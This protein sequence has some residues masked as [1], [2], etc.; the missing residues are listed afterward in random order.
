[1]SL[2]IQAVNIADKQYPLLLREPKWDFFSR[3]QVSRHLCPLVLA[4]SS[5]MLL[6]RVN[7]SYWPLRCRIQGAVRWSLFLKSLLYPT[8]MYS[9]ITFNRSFGLGYPAA[10][11]E[12]DAVSVQG[13]S[14]HLHV[15]KK[16]RT[17]YRSQWIEQ[18]KSTS[19]ANTTRSCFG[20]WQYALCFLQTL[21][22]RL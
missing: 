3:Y 12:H 22:G 19:T 20:D 15:Y 1:M 10:P 4:F 2:Y 13:M 16:T 18:K 5:V 9:A 6:R 8:K 11:R 14:V 17:S 7:T 21:R